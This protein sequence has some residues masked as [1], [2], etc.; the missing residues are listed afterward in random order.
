MTDAWE[1]AGRHVV[2]TG[3]SSGIG[4]AAAVELARAGATVCLV[5]RRRDRLEEVLGE[6]RRHSPQSELLVADL[7]ELDAIESV[8]D[9]ATS[10]LGGRV[11][12]L[13]NNAGVPKRRSTTTMT[14]ADVEEVMATNYF[15]P[16]RLTLALLPGMLEHD[17]GDVLNVSSMGAHMVAYKV[18]AYAASKAALEMFT[19]SLHVELGHTAVRAHL[20]VPGTT[21]TEFSTPKDG[22]DPPFPTDPSTA[23]SA[24]DVATAL[25]RALGDERLITYATDRDAATSANK[26]A[27]PNAFLAEMRSV[28]TGYERTA[29][30]VP[31]RPET[32]EPVGA[33][34]PGRW[35]PTGSREPGSRRPGTGRRSHRRRRRRTRRRRSTRCPPGRP[36][37]PP[38]PR[39]DPLGRRR[40]SA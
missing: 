9:Q 25:V 8:A 37:A 32:T 40:W 15:S 39:G 26:A 24:E 12:V 18:G 34:G 5:A 6:V 13:V 16:V 28:F 29:L 11:D 23:A 19:E 14:P 35:G 2:L 7:S 10:L 20:F 1:G 4:A 31:H 3:A 30:K 21:L 27:D 22:N 17:H 33:Y 38:S 36:A